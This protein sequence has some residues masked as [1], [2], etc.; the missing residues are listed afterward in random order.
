MGLLTY[1]EVSSKLRPNPFSNDRSKPD[2]DI[3]ICF[4]MLQRLAY[5]DASVKQKEQ[6]KQHLAYFDALLE[7]KEQRK[8]QKELKD[9]TQQELI[10]FLDELNDSEMDKFLG[11][12]VHPQKLLDRLKP[13][14]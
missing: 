6:R 2:K 10:E 1:P 3:D 8:Q 14:S 13:D 9:V 11:S 5:F 7:Q 12:V 4:K